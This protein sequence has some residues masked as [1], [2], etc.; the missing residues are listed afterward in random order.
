[1]ITQKVSTISI[2]ES[3]WRVLRC[4]CIF[5]AGLH[6]SVV[7]YAELALTGLRSKV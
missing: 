1:M 4:S 3:F 2:D 6:F 5:D 7:D